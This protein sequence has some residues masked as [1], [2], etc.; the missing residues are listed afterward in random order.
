M[1][2]S[3]CESYLTPYVDEELIEEAS[4]GVEKHI[5]EC[6][7]CSKRVLVLK[8]NLGQIRTAARSAAIVAPPELRERVF[9]RLRGEERRRKTREWIGVGAAAAGVVMVAAGA[10]QEYRTWKFRQ[11]EQD[12]ARR[13]SRM[14]PLEIEQAQA[15]AIEDWFGGKLDHHVSVP[16]FPDA[17]ARGARILQVRD[18]PAAYIRYAG[19]HPFGLFVYNDEDH[20]A[21]VGNEPTIG[22]ELGYTVLTWREGDLVYQLVGNY[23]AA[24]LGALASQI[25]RHGAPNFARAGPPLPP[26]FGGPPAFPAFGPPGSEWI[27]RPPASRPTARPAAELR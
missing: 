21:D 23:D 27:D 19:A 25:R 4:S 16:A 3:E 26:G 10:H 9:A 12:A 2:C 1:N 5:A 18:K 7:S 13:H 17:T 15:G 8:Q 24:Q 11:Y 6:P 20:D 22:V 14:F